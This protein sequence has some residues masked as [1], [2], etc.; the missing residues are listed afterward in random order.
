[1]TTSQLTHDRD[2]SRLDLATGPAM[3][4]QGLVPAL[5]PGVTFFSGFVTR[6]DVLAAGLLAVA[7][8]AG[9][10]YADLG[11]AA[12][13]K[14]AD[15]VVTA[16]GDRLRFESL[17]LCNG[18]HARLD[19]LPDGFGSS[20]VGFG[21]TNV[22][23]NQPLRTALARVDR[24]EPLHLAVGPDELRASSVAASYVE[25]KVALPDRWVRG[26]AETATLLHEMSPAATSTGVEARRFFA[27]LSRVAAPGPELHVVP[28]RGGWRT[29]TSATTASIPVFGAT[30]L[31]G[32]DRVLRHATRLSVHRHRHGSTAW[33]LDLPGA[34]FTIA[35]SPGLYRG[36]SGEGTLL[37]L[38]SHPDAETTG[39]Q[40]LDH[41]GWSATIDP[42][43]LARTSGLDRPAVR[44]GLGWLAASGR[45][46]FD[47]DEAAWFHREL[48]IDSEAVIRRN[49]RLTSAQRLADTGGV[50]TATASSWQVDGSRGATYDVT[51]AADAPSGLRCTCRWELDHQGTRGPCKH[52]LAVMLH[53]R[54]KPTA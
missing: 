39:R 32:T 10:R 40:L 36:F 13:I 19:V 37:A 45:V 27:G 23:V 14:A 25:P 47:L 3:T 8:I 11:V 48:P 30:R 42:D 52:L 46:G 5:E 12:R 16:S 29:T 18:V 24:N 26:L 21:T 54:S 7:D 43:D 35:F 20:E 38:L 15:P 44:A 53:L 1:M 9:S 41:L 50:R 17:S 22:D 28:L 33:V 34:R 2:G 49:P 51:P 31:R 6:P 4:P